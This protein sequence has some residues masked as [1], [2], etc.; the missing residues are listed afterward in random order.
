MSSFITKRHI[1]RR[2]V[3]RGIGAT[4]ALPLLDGMIPAF[5]AVQKAAVRRFGAIYLP[6][7]M[8][9][10][11]WTP[12]TE[13]RGFDLSPIMQPLA[14]FRDQLVILSG[15]ANKEADA[16]PGD[17]GGDHSRAQTAY[18][19]GLHAKKTEGADIEAGI[20]V[21]QIVAKELGRQTQLS[22]LELALEANELAGGCEDAYSCAYTGTIAW[23][24][25]NTPLPME[26]N[27][28]AVFE[29]LFGSSDSTDRK[30]RLARIKKDR[31]VLDAVTSELNDL[32]RTLGTTDHGKLTEYL[33]SVRDV[34]RRIQ[35]A[36]EQSDRELPTVEQPR[37][38]PATFEE[39]AKVMFDLLALAYQTDLTRVCTFLMGREKSVRSYPEIGV[40]EPHHPVSHHQRNPEMMEKLAK[41]NTYHVKMFAHLLDRLRSTPDGDGSL[42]DHVMIVY[43][44]GMSNSDNHFHHDLPIL[45]AG[46][47]AGQIKGGRHLRLKYDTPMSNLHL[48]VLDKMGI[49]VERFGDSEGRIDLLSDV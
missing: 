32:Q 30:A 13:G 27:P 20:S 35:K 26:H 11:N 47:G 42:L 36:E 8:N 12:T 33:E 25:A 38:I 49:P 46:G 40:P 7:G 28:R 15:L 5:A 29:R 17:G 14:P 41:V 39:H 44:A 23:R 48:T 1:N 2:T 16:K 31:S 6:N 18:L 19:T 3:L 10:W 43:G 9:I 22:S 24:T 34:E 4:L 21:D 45:L 37:G